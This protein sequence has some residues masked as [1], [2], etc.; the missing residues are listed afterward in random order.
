MARSTIGT[1]PIDSFIS[2]RKKPTAKANKKP[3]EP[4]K[5]PKERVTV[6]ITSEIIERARDVVFWTPGLTVSQL[7]ED[8]L[9]VEIEKLEKK[10]GKAFPERSGDIKTGRPVR[11]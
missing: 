10:R 5:E 4:E 9:L 1:T 8:A 2:G 7:L 11:K 6:L 3:A